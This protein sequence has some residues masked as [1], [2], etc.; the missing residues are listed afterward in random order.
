MP[1][2]NIIFDLGGVLLRINFKKTHA[3]FEALGITDAA[4]HFSQ[5]H[6]SELFEKL[7]TGHVTPL[8]FF[9]QFR[10]ITAVTATNEQIRDA[11]NAMLLNFPPENIALLETLSKKYNI[12]L[13][14]NTNELHYDYFTALFE[15]TFEGKKLNSLFTQAWYSHQKGIRKPHSSAFQKLL[16]TEA[17]KPEQTLFIDDTIGNTAGA[18]SVGMHT[19]LLK[20][21]ADLH[22]LDL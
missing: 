15:K 21:P 10:E 16:E 14:S 2:K 11:W 19:V 5:H 6:A 8:A 17:L 4:E 9:D 18:A 7:E 20:D 13:F 22:Q 12:Y 3:A 1:I